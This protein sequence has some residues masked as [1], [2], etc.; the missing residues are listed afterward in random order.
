MTKK[1]VGI[2]PTGKMIQ[3]PTCQVNKT[4]KITTTSVKDSESRRGG[5]L[6]VLEKLRNLGESVFQGFSLRVSHLALYPKPKTLV[7]NLG[8]FSEAL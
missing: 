1:S 2:G 6:G 8:V 7:E 5:K 3:P 4:N